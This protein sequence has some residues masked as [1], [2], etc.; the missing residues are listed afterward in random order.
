LDKYV[1]HGGK[2]LEGEIAVSG[3]KNASL[4]M[5]PAALL[6]AEGKVVLSNVPRLDDVFTML[7]VLDVLGLKS[8]WPGEHSVSLDA[9]G[10]LETLA[11][12]ELVRKMRPA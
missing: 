5:Y 3:S 10:R 2:R 1:I 4:P 6:A 9:T 12:Y 11:P 7:K 8:G